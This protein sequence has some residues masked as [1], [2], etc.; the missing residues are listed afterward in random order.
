VGKFRSHYPTLSYRY[1]LRAI[2]EAIYDGWS[3]RVPKR[4]AA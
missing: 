4:A 2:L 1:D 3:T